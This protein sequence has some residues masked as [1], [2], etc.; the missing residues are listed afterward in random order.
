MRLNVLTGPNSKCWLNDRANGV[1][2][3]QWL[4]YTNSGES[5]IT[6]GVCY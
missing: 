4:S 6:T 5:S 2:K 1:V 3:Y